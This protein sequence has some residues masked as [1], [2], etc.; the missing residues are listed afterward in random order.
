MT[1]I[2]VVTSG[3]GGVGKTTTSVNVAASLAS[4]GYKTAIVDFDM[5]L[6]NA[7]LLLGVERGIVY[8]LYDL[9]EQ[10]CNA[11]QALVKIKAVQNLYLVAADHRQDANSLSEE[12]VKYALEQLKEQGF[13][14]IV[15]DSPAGIETGAKM[16]MHFADEALV[17]VNPEVSSIRDADRVMGMLDSLTEA[18]KTKGEM[19][20][21]I[22]ITRYDAKRVADGNSV[23]MEDIEQLLQ[24]KTI[25]LIP[26]DLEVLTSSNAG[27]PVCLNEQTKAG[28]AYQDLASRL[29]G[30]DV[31]LK[32]TKPEEAEN[33]LQKMGRWFK[34]A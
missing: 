3:K 20:K 19:T 17:V 33:L 15:C 29:L 8:T 27:S 28:T 14:Y 32:F 26:E 16:A 6:R 13:E 22:V 12:K 9:C 23:S 34:G 7:D 1:K 10:K 4:K 11:L 30:Q 18:A 5:G 2:I 31:A 25:G 24:A 21:H